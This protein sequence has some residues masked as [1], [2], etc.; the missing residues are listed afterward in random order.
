MKIRFACLATC[1][2]LFILPTL[3]FGTS[4]S[5]ASSSPL[6]I[7]HINNFFERPPYKPPPPIIKQHPPHGVIEVSFDLPEG[8]TAT[9]SIKPENGNPFHVKLAPL[10]G[11]VQWQSRPIKPGNYE[12]TLTLPPKY[13]SIPPKQM[14]LAPKHRFKFSPKLRLSQQPASLKVSANIS[15]AIFILRSNKTRDESRG[16]GKEFTFTKLP[17]GPYTLSFASADPNS[18]MA[19]DEVSFLLNDHMQKEIKVTYELA[20]KVTIRT[21]VEGAEVLIQKIDGA[22]ENIKDE[23][24]QGAKTFTLAEGRYTIRLQPLAK[25]IKAKDIKAM[26]GQ[27]LNLV[28]PAPLTITVEPLTSK[29]YN[30]FYEE[31]SS[32]RE[33][34]AAN[35]MK[36]EIS[37]IPTDHLVEVAAGPAIIGNAASPPP[38]IVNISA[39]SIGIYEVTNAQYATWLTQALKEKKIAYVEE[40]D[41]RGQVLDMQGHLLFK[42][43][44]ADP[45]SQI[46]LQNSTL[47]GRKFIPLPG[48]D[49]YPVIN[50]SWYGAEAFCKDLKCRLPTEAE[51]EKAAAMVPQEV[52]QVGSQEAQ[53]NNQP[54][55]KETEP[56]PLKKFIFGFGQDVI[57]STW[58]NYKSENRPIQKFRV[59]TTPVGFYNGINT[60]PLTSE[61]RQPQKTHLAKSP[62]GAF[63]MSGNVW[64]WVSDWDGEMIDPTGPKT[65]SLKVAKGG[66]YDSLKDGVRVTERIKLKPD[67]TDAYTGFRVAASVK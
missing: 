2:L 30:L 33:E 39:F 50:V 36:T 63:D 62:Y 7:V 3:L 35:S 13:E 16:G 52:P 12:I 67:H 25:D 44:L 38:K 58:A 61:S 45:Y 14:H 27:D 56:A 46:D 1:F 8:E 24:R 60:L 53:Q 4:S 28:P 10:N 26:D 31:A 23:I 22:K 59:L 65:G 47:E 49:L 20:G 19:P 40:A 64:E 55:V 48:K 11:K 54:V 17:A 66:C 9:V 41:R 32:V 34:P 42:T 6:G 51:W 21:N 29:D 18:Y 43:F 57:D 15:S 37:L 5:L